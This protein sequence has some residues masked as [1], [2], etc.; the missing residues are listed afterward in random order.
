[1]A[2][3]NTF[4]SNTKRAYVAAGIVLVGFAILAGNPALRL[5]L[6]AMVGGGVVLGALLIFFKERD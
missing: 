3:R 5:M 1:M 6:I 2:R 4:D